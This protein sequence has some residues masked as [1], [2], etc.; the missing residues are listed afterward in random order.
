LVRG[1][2]QNKVGDQK[3]FLLAGWP[4]AKFGSFLLWMI[5]SPPTWHNWKKQKNKNKKKNPGT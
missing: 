2:R 4:L 1:G 3:K 5:A